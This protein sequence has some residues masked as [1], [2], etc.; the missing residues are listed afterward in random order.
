MLE[1][2]T[3]TELQ[4]TDV[5]QTHRH[6]KNVVGVKHVCEHTTLPIGSVRSTNQS[7]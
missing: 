1:S 7:A 5:G 3:T 6:I 2:T 4:A